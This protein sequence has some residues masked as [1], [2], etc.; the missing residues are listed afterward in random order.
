MNKAQDLE[1]VKADNVLYF[2]TLSACSREIFV[3]VRTR[4]LPSEPELGRRFT[5]ETL[6]F[7]KIPSHRGLSY[8]QPS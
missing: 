7:P 5:R 8:G 2:S 3:A 4:L 1:R 6:E